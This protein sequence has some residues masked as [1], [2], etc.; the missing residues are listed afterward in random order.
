[1]KKK[2]PRST[3]R[4]NTWDPQKD[5]IFKQLAEA[6]LSQGYAVRREELK[7]G[8]GWKVASGSC[9]LDQQKLI[10]VDRKLPQDDQIAFLTQRMTN[11]G[12]RLSDEQLASLPEKVQQMLVAGSDAIAA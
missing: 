10:F 1:M 2:S 4:K 8:H 7:Q 12:V 11:A 9:R 5:N 6:M 3:A